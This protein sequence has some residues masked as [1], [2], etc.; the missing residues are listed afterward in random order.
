M[1]CMVGCASEGS[2]Q[3]QRYVELVSLG[4]VEAPI[5]IGAY[6]YVQYPYTYISSIL[7]KS[8]T[9]LGMRR[10]ATSTPE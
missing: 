5:L 8:G 4:W 6:F 2:G 10:D 9:K 7:R 3:R 1:A